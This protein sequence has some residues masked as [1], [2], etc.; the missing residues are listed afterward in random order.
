MELIIGNITFHHFTDE[1]KSLFKDANKERKALIHDVI[2]V[3][4][5]SDAE[6]AEQRGENALGDIAESYIIPKL[7]N[8]EI[9][10][11]NPI[12]NALNESFSMTRDNFFPCYR[13]ED[14]E[15]EYGENETRDIIE[16]TKV[17]T[18]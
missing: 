11:E 12:I 10:H 4:F 15:S 8:G 13:I 17:K 3:V 7:F 5:C 2:D 16:Q 1:E 14:F 18:L 9:K 6:E